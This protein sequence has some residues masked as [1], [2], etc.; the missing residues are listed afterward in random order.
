MNMY[1]FGCLSDTFPGRGEDYLA[2][3]IISMGISMFGNLLNVIL[4]E[5]NELEWITK[6]L[7]VYI[8]GH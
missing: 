6:E 2:S 3:K 1:T 5:K 8:M 7:D 4:V